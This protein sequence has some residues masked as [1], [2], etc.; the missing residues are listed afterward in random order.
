[1]I[2]PGMPKNIRLGGGR[3]WVRKDSDGPGYRSEEGHY[4]IRHCGH[5]AVLVSFIHEPLK[6]GEEF[7]RKSFRTVKKAME[8]AERM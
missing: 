5:Y 3:L 7:W 8:Y 2:S 4:D 1:M 6:K